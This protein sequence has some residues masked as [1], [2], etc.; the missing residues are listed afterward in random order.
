M[1][2]EAED[3][4]SG[5]NEE[6][7][8][9]VAAAKNTAKKRQKKPDKQQALDKVT[10]AIPGEG[11]PSQSVWPAKSSRASQE[12]SG[13]EKPI[14][15]LIGKSG[16]NTVQISVRKAS[17]VDSIEREVVVV[18]SGWETINHQISK[19]AEEHRQVLLE[20]SPEVALIVATTSGS[21]QEL[22]DPE[23][24]SVASYA[25]PDG[26]ELCA[27]ASLRY[28]GV[29]GKL[30]VVKLRDTELPESSIKNRTTPSEKL[31]AIASAIEVWNGECL[32]G[33]VPWAL[34]EPAVSEAIM[35]RELEVLA[36]E[37]Q[38]W[39]CGTLSRILHALRIFSPD[40]DGPYI[41]CLREQF[42]EAAAFC[43]VFLFFY[44]QALWMLLP[45]VILCL[46]LDWTPTGGSDTDRFEFELVKVVVIGWG[47]V[48]ASLCSTRFLGDQAAKELKRLDRGVS[49]KSLKRSGS[50][51]P[52]WYG[53]MSAQDRW[54]RLVFMAFPCLILFLCVCMFTF[55]MVTNLILHI[56]Y[57]WGDCYN[58]HTPENVCRD[59]QQ[60]HGIPGWAAEVACDI[61]LA[62]L[63]EVFF[64]V[65]SLLAKWV[66]ELLDFDYINDQRYFQSMMEVFLSAVERIG[67]VSTL[68]FLFVP[69]WTVP[70][71]KDTIDMSISCSDLTLGDSSF[72]CFQ[73]RLPLE[74]RRWLLEKLMK[75][76][77]MVA[78]FVAIFIKTILPVV[79]SKLYQACELCNRLPG[80]LGITC[81]PCRFI[82]RFFTLIFTLDGD[83]V[84]CF[85][86]ACKGWP[87]TEVTLDTLAAG[88]ES[89]AA[90]APPLEE[91]RR[92]V[93]SI[94][95]QAVK[96][97]FEPDDELMEIEMSFLWV[98][99]FT[100]LKPFGVI[101]TL[102]AKILEIQFDLLK[103]VHVRRR[104]FPKC[105]MVLRR[106]QAAF[107]NA[108]LLGSI[109]WSLGL[110]FITYNDDLYKLGNGGK[111]ILFAVFLWL[112]LC[113]LLGFS[114]HMSMD[115]AMCYGK[116][117][118]R[119]S[120]RQAAEEIRLNMDKE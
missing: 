87:F 60:K 79:V 22:D 56:I 64:P 32:G 66:S 31:A 112:F 107:L 29:P 2:A 59:A 82:V 51:R 19:Q 115:V 62:L 37:S 53:E 58:R 77:F 74:L 18:N 95:R 104:A 36:L 76:P 101:T 68:A 55:I 88:G 109:G 11:I 117:R 17:T 21:A 85:K 108:V 114:K 73:R 50:A 86:F 13:A 96:K 52:N 14:A 35:T 97:P 111:L 72:T 42:G 106:E 41:G 102:I 118:Q 8:L 3:S 65:S 40:E 71:G 1:Y 30:W 12:A 80:K 93:F 57:V 34:H 63:F 28:H 10:L 70:N 4:G 98:L 110:S 24:S 103:M 90:T 92:G 7:S 116:A 120:R 45:F 81:A 20:N 27:S 105:D 99:F 39:F 16:G 26:L 38:T 44:T 94:L 83:N 54:L 69:Q 75:G 89:V 67:F 61:L 100:P 33:T 47:A 9:T 5:T 91:Y 15:A 49:R 48:I 113:A 46:L 84:G 119:L 23:S 43:Q 25:L 6:N 78:P